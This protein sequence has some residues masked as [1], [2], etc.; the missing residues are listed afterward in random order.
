MYVSVTPIVLLI[1]S[2]SVYEHVALPFGHV[3]PLL[4]AASKRTHRVV[5]RV[6]VHSGLGGS[7]PA[8]ATL[9]LCESA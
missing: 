4:S 8:V 1:A 6:A 5:W 7:S 3:P 9:P 2:V